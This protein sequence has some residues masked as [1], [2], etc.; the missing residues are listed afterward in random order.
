M[1]SSRRCPRPTSSTPFARPSAAT[2]ERSPGR[3]PTTSPRARSR[4]SSERNELDAARRSTTSSWAARTRPA[5]T[6]ATS[7]AWP[8]LLAGLPVEVPASRSTGSAPPGLEAVDQAGPRVRPGEARLMLAGGV[9][10]MTLA[11]ARRAQAAS[12]AS[13]A[14]RAART[15]P[16]GWR[17]VNPRMA[18]RTRPS[19]WASGRER[20][21]ALRRHPRGRRR[22]VR[23]RVAAPRA[24]RRTEASVIRR[25]DRAPSERARS[26]RAT[27]RR[28]RRRGIAADATIVGRNGARSYRCCRR[29]PSRREWT[30]RCRCRRA[31]PS[32]P[33]S[34]CRSPGCARS[35]RCRRRGRSRRGWT[36]RSPYRGR[37]CCP[38]SPCPCRC[39]SRSPWYRCRWPRWRRRCACRSFRPSRR[40]WWF[41]MS[42]SWCRRHRRRHRCPDPSCR[43]RHHG[44]GRWPRSRSPPSTARGR[45]RKARW[46]A[47]T[48]SPGRSEPPRRRTP[49]AT[50]SAARRSG[51]RGPRTA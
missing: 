21:R 28:A 22:G 14:E 36:C 4:R 27:P 15:P 44:R 10:S 23:A 12:A 1:T 5:R 30:C 6:T 9:E 42:R 13:R 3:G 37:R 33:W 47:R 39:R 18:E 49:R 16:I 43:R 41:R 51:R 26:R 46:K 31:G 25:G 48:R 45:R 50:S 34:P 40:W 8:G 19:R 35:C 32:R 29:G 11:P 24:G 7:P 38:W 20:G 17:F 2:A